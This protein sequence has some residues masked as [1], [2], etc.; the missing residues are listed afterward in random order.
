MG[1]HGPAGR[2]G[3]ARGVDDRGQIVRPQHLAAAAELAGVAREEGFAPDQGLV[4]GHQA[5]DGLEGLVEDQGQAQGRHLGGD[6]AQLGELGGGGGDDRAGGAIVERP[7][8]RLGV[9]GGVEGH[10]H[11]PDP[12]HRLIG[13]G[14]LEAV[15][16]Q[17]GHALADPDA[18]LDQVGAEGVHLAGHLAVGGGPVASPFLGQERRALGKAGDRRLEHRGNGG[19]HVSCYPL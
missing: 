1:E 11:G 7:G 17:Q 19:D 12:E 4:V 16:A 6:L 15:L 13:D 5:V 10:V 3:G 9:E 8:D 14:P 18:A 2:A